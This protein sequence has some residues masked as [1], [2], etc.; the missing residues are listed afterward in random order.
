[1]KGVVSRGKPTNH[2]TSK[3]GKSLDHLSRGWK[4][5]GGQ[6]SLNVEYTVLPTELM[7]CVLW[8]RAAYRAILIQIACSVSVS[9]SISWAGFVF[10]GDSCYEQQAGTVSRCLA[11]V[12]SQ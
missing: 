7:R 12:N 11:A 10:R 6:Y 9:I 4:L 5:L 1:M 3:S 8:D 2:G